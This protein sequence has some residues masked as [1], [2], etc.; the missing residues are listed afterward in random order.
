MGRDVGSLQNGEQTEGHEVNPVFTRHDKARIEQALWDGTPEKVGPFDGGC[1]AIARAL[2]RLGGEVE[3]LV[4]R[5][6]R[7][8][9]AVARFGSW[10]VDFKGALPDAAMLEEFSRAELA[11]VCSTRGIR[12]GDLGEAYEN[13]DLVDTI[14]EGIG[15]Q[16]RMRLGALAS[17]SRAAP[18]RP[19]PQGPGRG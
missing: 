6:D 7:A 9:H 19:R 12:D 17:S 10:L 5:H 14:L 18:A 3:V 15:E 16:A 8:Q 4:D 13:K 11:H 2:E 1:L